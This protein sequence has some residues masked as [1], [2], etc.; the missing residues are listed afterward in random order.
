MPAPR[1]PVAKLKAKGAHLKNQARFATRKEPKTVPLGEPSP[2][3]N[4]MAKCAWFAFQSELPWLS[5]SDR[6]VMELA[7]H[8]RGKLMAGEDPSPAYLTLLRQSLQ[9][10][11]AT[12]ADRSR[13]PAGD[14][15]VSVTDPVEKFFQ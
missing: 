8:I 6:G 7:C 5:E 15:G 14:D 11:G 2:H 3:L 12:P 9:T 4:P 1:E 13:V 10:M